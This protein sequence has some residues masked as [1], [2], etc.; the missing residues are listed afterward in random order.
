MG[1]GLA[2]LARHHVIVR[3]TF[4]DGASIEI[5]QF[6]GTQINTEIKDIREKLENQ[7]LERHEYEELQTYSTTAVIARAM[8]LVGE[9]G[10]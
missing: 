2:R 8:A 6:S 5:I 10:V 7:V 1:L 9:N 3:Q 4:N